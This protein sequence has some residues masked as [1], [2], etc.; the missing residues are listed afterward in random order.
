MAKG[1]KTGGGS[2][3]GV[4]NRFTK[5]LKDMILGALDK[6]GGEEYLVAQAHKNPGPFMSMLSKVMPLQVSGGGGGPLIIR[7]LR[8][9]EPDGTGG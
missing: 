2:R 9:G 4:P 5:T 6:A 8:D 3:A 7:W 1:R